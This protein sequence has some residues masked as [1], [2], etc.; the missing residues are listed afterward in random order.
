MP[1]SSLRWSILLLLVGS[2]AKAGDWPQIL[3]PQRNGQAIDETL[4]DAWPTGGPPIVWNRPI[5]SGFAGPAIVDGRVILFHRKDDQEIVEALALADG[6][7]L[8][9]QKFPARYEATISSDDGPRC[10]PLVH[11]NRVYVLGAAGLAAALQLDD[12][13]VVWQ[14]ELA[15]DY[16]LRP[17]YFG[18]GSTPILEDGKLLINLGAEPAAGIV[19][20]DSKSGKTAWTVTDEQAS[21]SSPVAATIDSVRHIF[22]ITRYQFLSLDPANG[23]VRFRFPF[24]QRGPTV[25]GANPLVIDRNVFLSS[26]YGVGARLY[27][28]NG[29]AA[30]E[31][32]S[33]DA[34]MSSQYMTSVFCKGAVYGVDGRDDVGA[35]ALRCFDPKTG[36]LHWSEDNFGV[37]TIIAAGN[38]LLLVKT[39]GEIVLADASPKAYQE[40]GRAKLSTLTIRAL[41]A[42]S[43][44]KLVVRDAETLYCVGVR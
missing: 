20:L 40:Q 13:K 31:Q 9:T 5:G 7:T 42:V 36:E 38:R 37:A 24:G 19:A 11:D 8:W 27:Q 17:S 22:F 43:N 1:P 39:N 28:V 15:R 25:N 6:K 26:S 23:Q 2:F 10:V 30:A 44:G 34:L 3:G 16:R 21:Y 29:S 41:P 12:G 4:S 18:V 32:W 35:T 33:R 14:R